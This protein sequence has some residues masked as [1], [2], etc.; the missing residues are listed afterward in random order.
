MTAPF[1]IRT[2]QRVVVDSGAARRAI[3]L[4]TVLESALLKPCRCL[5]SPHR[6]SSK[7]DTMKENLRV[8]TERPLNAETPTECLRSW[9]T[10][11]S[12][13]FDRN[14]GAIPPRRIPLERWR[15]DGGR[16]GRGAVH[17]DLRPDPPHAQGDRRRHPGVF[18]QR[19]L[20][21]VRTSGREPVDDRRRGQCGLGRRV[22]A[23]RARPRRPRNRRPRTSPSRG[24]TGRSGPPGSSSS[25]ASRWTRRSPR[26]CSPTR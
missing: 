16:G 5:R 7:E 6:G 22:A 11:N 10:P 8:M 23:G 25:A 3:G 18:G 12:V 1:S 15:L 4:T 19:A 20:A 13:F 2:R 9:I 24:S 17:P 26:P 14:Q 21:P